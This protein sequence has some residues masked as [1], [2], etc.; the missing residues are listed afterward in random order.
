[1]LKGMIN[2]AKH[3]INLYYNKEVYIIKKEID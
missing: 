3:A 1:M 2:G